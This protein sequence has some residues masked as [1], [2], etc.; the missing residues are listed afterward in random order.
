MEK[1]LEM[2]KSEVDI[3]KKQKRIGFFKWLFS[4]PWFWLIS[5]PWSILSGLEDLIN[6]NFAGY[7]GTLG[8]VLFMVGIAFLL[9]YGVKG[10]VSKKI[11]EE[12]KKSLKK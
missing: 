2:P 11:K 10:Y 5:I 6:H 9:I 12:V 3:N 7:L 1:H 4:N 8:A